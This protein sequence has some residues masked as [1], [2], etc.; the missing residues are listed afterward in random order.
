MS[1]SEGIRGEAIA[2]GYLR[3]KGYRLVAHS[4]HC[5][6][7]EIDLIA[8]DHKTLCFVEV[9]TR[10]NLSKGLPRHYVTTQKQDRLRKTAMLYLQEKD[11]DC[12]CRFDVAEIYP[13]NDGEA[14]RVEYLENAFE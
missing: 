12:A 10:S 5:R 9:K 7:G 11:L 3:E 14:F 1:R 8:W 2:A 4:Y 13:E 6:F